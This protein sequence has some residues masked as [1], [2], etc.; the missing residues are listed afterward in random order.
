MRPAGAR[1]TQRLKI[2]SYDVKAR[3]NAG[4]RARLRE[5]SHHIIPAK[6]P[7]TPRLPID[8]SKWDALLKYVDAQSLVDYRWWN[9]TG[10]QDLE[11]YLARPW[12]AGMSPDEEKAAL[13]NACNALTV[14]WV[15]Q[16]FPVTSIWRTDGPFTAV[17]HTI[18]GRNVSLNQIEN[19]LRDAG[20]PRIHAALVCASRSCPPLRCRSRWPRPPG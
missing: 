4:P 15:L 14:H 19:R 20:D 18:N 2:P 7:N 16:N 17:R 12:P 10:R 9:Q 8:H 11:A 3:S 1:S 13:I 5:I 6:A